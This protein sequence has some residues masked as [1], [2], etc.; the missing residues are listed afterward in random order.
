MG[1]LHTYMHGICLSAA[2]EIIVQNM[3]VC[4]I[5]Y[6]SI[7]KCMYVSRKQQTYIV[8]YTS[9]IYE[10]E[11]TYTY[12]YIYQQKAKMAGKVHQQRFRRTE[13]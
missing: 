13:H 6:T 12:V 9:A 7:Q 3:H 2:A 11:Y 5:H 1:E 8:G 10:P 4:R